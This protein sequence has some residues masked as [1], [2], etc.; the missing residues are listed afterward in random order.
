MNPPTTTEHLAHTGF[1]APAAPSL[2]L[3]VVGNCAFSA[4]IDPHGR[5]VWSCLPRFDGDPVFHALLGGEDGAGA[6]AIEIEHLDKARQYYDP[7]T[8]VLHTELWDT[9]GQ[10]ILITDFA[11]RFPSRGRFFR[12]TMLVRRVRPLQGAPRVRVSLTPRFNWGAETPTITSGSNHIRYVGEQQ[13]LRLHTDASV[14]HVLSHQPFLLTRELNFLLGPDETLEGGVG[15]T[16]RHFEQETLT[17][18]R[19]WSQRLALPL[20]W[21][22]AV[23]RAAITLK[24]SM[25]ED[26][27]AIV[28]AMTTSIPE[29]PGTQRNWD[30]R[31][32][33]LRDAF[34]VV[35]ALN[36]LAE[37]GT[38]EDYLRWLSNAV[39]GS[40]GGH[41]QPLF[42]IGLERD[43][44]ERICKNLPGYRGMGPVRVGNQAHEHFQ[45]DV[46]GNIVLGA[47][48]AFHDRRLLNPAGLAEF[49]QLEAAGEK[50]VLIFDQP[51]AGMW[52]LRTR[53]R[54]HTSSALMCW[55]ACDRLAKIALTLQ[56]GE[57][58]AY[59]QQHA[60]AMR[61]R[62]LRESWS[63][64][65]QAFAAAFGAHDL[66]ASVLLMAEVGFIDPMD[67]R[68]IAT[69]DALEKN[70]CDGPYMR[71][72]DA[73]D[74]FGKPEVAFNI[75]TFW[76]IDALAR[77][78][79]V[80]EARAIF[81]TMLRARNPLGML[82]EDTHATTGEMWG[83]YP[84][85]YSMVGII[86]AAVRL[87]AAWDTVI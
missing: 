56:Q 67:P 33:W 34:F 42:G 65:R 38:M 48:Q 86:N 13:T 16:A 35:R 6:F 5:V 4:L 30:Y 47:A 46:Y 23:I 66:D 2:S 45:H 69:L 84:Q 87:S 7:N 57:R 19:G 68:F 72:Y 1:A 53:A 8:A 9:Q 21:Q 44:P 10:G 55:A 79:R 20:E 12:P 81:E 82:S 49:K 80:D 76:R 52:E 63:E 26:T 54:V 71:R 78:G 31:Y 36:S 32:C 58:A 73:A 41:V 64:E 14:S 18:W 15:E 62:I 39:V 51:D 43:L 74:D 37:V 24:L 61:E 28:A 25:F 85:T 27:G 77:V 60:R 75:C 83:N 3:G 59:W 17:Y 70:L 29:A 22:E 40:N 50:A 11:P